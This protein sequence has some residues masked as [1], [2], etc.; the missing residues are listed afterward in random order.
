MANKQDLDKILMNNS[1]GPIMR[2]GE[3]ADAVVEAAV[4]DNPDKNIVVDDKIAYKR[5]SADGE[6]KLYRK[7]IETELGRPF[8]MSEM[9]IDLASFAGRIKMTSEEVTFFYATVV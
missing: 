4:I 2:A 1:V 5:I 6:L 7:T 9:E 8:L 3:V